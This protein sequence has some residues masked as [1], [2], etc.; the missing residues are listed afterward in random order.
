M[1]WN[2]MALVVLVFIVLVFTNIALAG[3]PLEKDDGFL[4]GDPDH[5]GV[6]N[7]DEFLVGTDPY[8]SDSDNDG[9]P[10]WWELEYSPWRN[11][12]PNANMDPTD[13]SDAHQDFDYFQR[14]NGTGYDR[15][16]I[17][18][19]FNAIEKLK[20]GGLVVWPSN[21]TIGFK[22]LVFDEVSPHYDNYEEYYRPYTDLENGNL[23]RY[24]HTNPT[25]PD[26]DGDGF[27]DPDDSEPIGKR[28]DGTTPGGF[29][30]QTIIEPD[31]PDK[32]THDDMDIVLTTELDYVAP[33]IPTNFDSIFI[34]TTSDP[35]QIKDIDGK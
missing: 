3:N 33:I 7:R 21:P 13:S 27:L 14:S 1:K 32:E 9:L 16:E 26:T 28:N 2:I 34:Q 5:D 24:M 23:I 10:D 19:K 6:I 15:G 30:V 25:N 29:D 18:A 11:P 12:N 4:N 35:G 31:D 20:G 22:T 8:N 17:E